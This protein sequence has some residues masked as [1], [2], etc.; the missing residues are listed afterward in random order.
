MSDYLT[1]HAPSVASPKTLG[2]RSI[3]ISDWWAERRVGE[4]NKATCSQYVEHRRAQGRSTG[5]ARNELLMLNAALNHALATGRLESAPKVT[6]PP[7]GEPKERWLTRDEAARLLRAA[8]SIKRC[9]GY[10]PLF[11]LLGLYGGAR[12]EAI[13]S[14]RWH[15]VDLVRQRLDWNPE[16]RKRTKKG[17]PVI[18]IPS[19]LATFLR[20]AKARSGDMEFVIS[21][22]DGRR[23]GHVRRGFET[24]C[25]LAGLDGVTPHTLRHTCGTWLAQAGTPLWDIAGWLG[26]SETTTTE[27]YAH[28]SPEHTRRAA[29]ALDRRRG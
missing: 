10:L 16:G 9:R 18:S 21:G 27:L 12:K 3:P 22:G 24:A 11:I 15:Q 2:Y 6:L 1:E 28:H 19:R 29:A 20:Y 13:L 5:T 17:R 14:L 23:I 8:R 26:H 4:I 7:R 25:R